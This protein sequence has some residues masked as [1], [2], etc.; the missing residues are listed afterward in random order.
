MLSKPRLPVFNKTDTQVADMNDGG[1]S[2]FEASPKKDLNG[3]SLFSQ[4]NILSTKNIY[5]NNTSSNEQKEGRN[6]LLAISYV[7]S[8]QAQQERENSKGEINR[9]DTAKFDDL[10]KQ[11][12]KV[13]I[14]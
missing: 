10:S 13:S 2:S 7:E 14:E 9:M 6:S 8:Q 4:L 3:D 5:H 12:E 11:G 1:K